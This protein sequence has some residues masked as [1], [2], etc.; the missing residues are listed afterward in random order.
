[1]RSL[2]LFKYTSR[3]RSTSW[4]IALCTMFI[5]ASFSV[6]AGLQ[7]S[8]DTLMDNFSSEYYLVTRQ[9]GTFPGTFDEDEVLSS[10]DDVAFGLFRSILVE[11][12]YL[13][14]IA[15]CV[16]DVDGVLPEAF[17]VEG[18]E[19][20][21]GQDL[22]LAGSVALSSDPLVSATVV[23]KFSSSMFPSDWLLCSEELMRSVVS[24]GE[25]EWNFAIVA[26]PTAE[27]ASALRDGGF[28]VQPMIAILEFLE[29][30]MEE[31]R[32]DALLV[33]MPSSVVVGVL[34]YSFLGSEVADRRREIGILKTIGAGRKRLFSYLLTNALLITAWGAAL[35]LAL[36]IILSYGIA[37]AASHIFT[38]VFVIEIEE[39]LLLIAYSA[40]LA[41]GLVGTLIPALRSTFTSPVEDLKEVRRF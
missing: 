37:T 27:Q 9:T 13:E 19:A 16:V 22:E 23:G 11:P 25:G 10:V 24:A 4:M 32:T 39:S 6:A 3:A 36:G 14:T 33:L 15:F 21:A 31:I 41:A 2:P 30:G 29:S 17:F 38:S 34:V 8:M 7:S 35:G 12:G 1:M 20:L 28:V 26:D 5:V 40:T 18:D